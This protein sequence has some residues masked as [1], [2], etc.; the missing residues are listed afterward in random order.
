MLFIKMDALSV[1]L[2][3]SKVES[4]FFNVGKILTITAL[5]YGYYSKG[6]AWIVKVLNNEAPFTFYNSW[7]LWIRFACKYKVFRF[8]KLPRSGHN[9]TILL[10]ERSIHIRLSRLGKIG[11]IKVEKSRISVSLLYLHKISFTLEKER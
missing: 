4:I 11:F 2:L 9:S 7:K 6:F 8:F 3:V 1:Y 5:N 10:W